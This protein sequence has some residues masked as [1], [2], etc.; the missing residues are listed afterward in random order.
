MVTS[1]AQPPG[2]WPGVTG[3]PCSRLR[4][5]WWESCE[6]SGVVDEVTV[7]EA[8]SPV[9]VTGPENGCHAGSEL[10]HQT[11]VVGDTGPQARM[12]TEVNALDVAVER[13]A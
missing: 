2:S 3:V 5:I 12:S 7:V 8:Q 11:R 9:T 6:R 1:E 4:L 10:S 13:S